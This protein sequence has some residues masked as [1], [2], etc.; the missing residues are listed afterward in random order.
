MWS[1]WP[2]ISVP[3]KGDCMLE[4]GTALRQ[5]TA[6]HGTVLHNAEILFLTKNVHVKLV[7][8]MVEN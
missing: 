6:R 5:S 1:E 3:I 4:V 2:S 7:D 8:V